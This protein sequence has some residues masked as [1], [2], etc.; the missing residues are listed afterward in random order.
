LKK[1][2]DAWTGTYNA[3]KAANPALASELETAKV[4]AHRSPLTA[5]HTLV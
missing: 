5:H 3:W 4:G 1:E 2:Y